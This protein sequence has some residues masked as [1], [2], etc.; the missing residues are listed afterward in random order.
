MGMGRNL[1]NINS[2]DSLLM[3]KAHEVQGFWLL[4]S[5]IKVTFRQ[6][7]MHVM[8]SGRTSLTQ[9]ILWIYASA[10]CIVSQDYGT[11]KRCYYSS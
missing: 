5:C 4:Y 7:L 6:V 8:Y 2:T 9:D 10:H 11:E 1:A 3:R